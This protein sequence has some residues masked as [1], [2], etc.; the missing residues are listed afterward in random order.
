MADLRF[1]GPELAEDLRDAARFDA[2]GEKGVEL[3]GP[4]RDGDEFAAAL[5]HFGG[6]GEAH[7]DE[8][9]RCVRRRA[10]VFGIGV[11]GWFEI[12]VACLR[13]GSSSLSA[14]ISP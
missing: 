2:A 4:G 1:A 9:R 13:R 5:V 10:S 14:R 11:A 12:G 3:F 7:G 8:F 6:G